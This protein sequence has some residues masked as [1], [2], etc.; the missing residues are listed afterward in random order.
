MMNKIS[1]RSFLQAA[2]VV[3]AAAALTACGGKTE[4]DKGSSQNGK[5]PD[6]LLPV[7]PLHDERALLRG[8]NRSSR[9]MSSTSFRASTPWTTTATC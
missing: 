2:G 7:G 5:D 4:A 8:W 3:A 1:R 9:S 6:H